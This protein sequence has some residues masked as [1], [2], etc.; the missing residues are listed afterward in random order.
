MTKVI[1]AHH[2]FWRTAEQEQPW[3]QA[4]HTRLERDFEP[5]DLT[6]ELDGA[7]V[8]S[9]VLM[10][11]V[12]EPA[13][14]QRLAAYAGDPR[15]AGVVA[16]LPLRDTAAARA[17]LAALRIPKLVGVRC[18]VARDPM[19]WLSSPSSVAL[20]QEIADRRLVWDVVPITLEQTRAVLELAK[21]VPTLR[22]VVD[23][24]GRP[25]LENQGWEP[26]ASHVRELA[27]CPNVALKVS[28]GIDALTAWSGWD[29][30]VLE[31][32]VRFVTE[33]F[34]PRRLMLASNWPVIL[35]R[36]T[37]H[38]AWTDLSRLVFDLLEDQEDREAVLGGTAERWYRLGAAAEDLQREEVA[39]APTI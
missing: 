30:S 15:I 12:D 20:F 21:R 35:L 10:Q 17:E 36:T 7:G 27:S 25:P 16:W 29:P 28:V 37:Y 1:D 23:H 22:I 39:I 13:E 3:R 4:S 26:W 6:P 31:P 24:L 9:T 5:G 11:S 33:A 32:Y 19:E 2:H 38:Q 8:G 14:N 34:G 18:L